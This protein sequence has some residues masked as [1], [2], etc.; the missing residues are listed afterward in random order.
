M[1]K[2]THPKNKWRSDI[3]QVR[4]VVVFGVTSMFFPRPA[5]KSPPPLAFAG[6]G[7]LLKQGLA[8]HC[9][10]MP[11][12]ADLLQDRVSEHREGSEQR[13]GGLY[14]H[15]LDYVEQSV[16]ITGLPPPP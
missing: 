8:S 4:M 14:G 15:L 9:I 6:E 16:H 2:L 11:C 5:C 7:G 3:Q 12:L 13:G 10:L 1:H